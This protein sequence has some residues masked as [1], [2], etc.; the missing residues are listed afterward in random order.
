[1]PVFISYSH[2]DAH[3]V[4]RLAA[5]L[6]LAKVH[7]WVDTWELHVG[8]SLISK[9]Q[10]AIQESSALIVVLSRNSVESEW[11]K[12]ELNAGLMREL[13]EKRVVVFP[14]LLEDCQIPLF[15]REKLY[16]DFRTNYDHGLGQVLEAVAKVTSTRRGR[17]DDPEWHTDWALDAGEVEEYFYLQLTFVAHSESQPYCVL[18]EVKMRCN[19]ITTARYKKYA[20]AGLESFGQLIILE[21]LRGAEELDN[22]DIIITD[23]TTQTKEFRAY[24][25]KTGSGLDGVVICRRLG[26][27]TGRDLFF[28]LGRQIAGTIAQIQHRM[29]PLTQEEREKVKEVFHRT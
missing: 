27:D 12:R 19:E 7:V 2:Q 21:C 11:C 14:A 24:D 5:H 23:D 1:M 26:E 25:P 20:E 29:R 3:F 16:A 28:H 13:E 4:N 22:L 17:V 10:Q 6:T 18:T 9:V 15:L 8:D